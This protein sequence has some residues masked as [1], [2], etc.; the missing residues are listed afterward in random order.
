MPIYAELSIVEETP[1]YKISEH[2][3]GAIAAN[4]DFFGNETVGAALRAS[5]AQYIE[6]NTFRGLNEENKQDF[7]KRVVNL[8]EGE[9]GLFSKSESEIK[10]IADRAILN[11]MEE[12]DIAQSQTP[13]KKSIYSYPLGY[14]ATDHVGY[15][16][17]D[18]S[19]IS[20]LTRSQNNDLA[21]FAR[22]GAQKSYAF[23]VYPMGKEGMR[24]SKVDL[25]MRRFLPSC[26][27]SN[28]H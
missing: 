8:L 6:E 5:L 11:A 20:D 10:E 1:P 17:F 25:P 2:D 22:N 15:A 27:L 16:S 3:L 19:R 21:A 18:L 23:F 4:S 12:F 7:L 24:L 28:P 26:Q 13:S 9:E 14:L